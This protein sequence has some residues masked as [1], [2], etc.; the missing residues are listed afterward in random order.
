MVLIGNEL[1]QDKEHSLNDLYP[2]V[3]LLLRESIMKYSHRK[4]PKPNKSLVP[5]GSRG[6]QQFYMDRSDNKEY[7]HSPIHTMSVKEYMEKKKLEEA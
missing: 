7:C 4:K 2:Y 5:K 6:I 1:L 3:Y